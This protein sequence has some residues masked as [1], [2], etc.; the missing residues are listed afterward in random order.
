M[1]LHAARSAGQWMGATSSRADVDT[2]RAQRSSHISINYLAA[3]ASILC[4]NSPE[5]SP[6][7]LRLEVGLLNK[8][9][10]TQATSASSSTDENTGG[11]RNDASG[12]LKS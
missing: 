6:A 10:R 11:A 9:I 1:L 3:Y 2:R 12:K 5:L 4:Y 8:S 7:Q